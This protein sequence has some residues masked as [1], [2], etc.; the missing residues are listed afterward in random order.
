RKALEQAV[1][2]QP[3][4]APALNN[5]GYVL[6]HL[7]RFAEAAECYGQAIAVNPNYAEAYCNLASVRALAGDYD[8]ALALARRAIELKP[9]YL[10]PP[11]AAAVVEA[12]RGRFDE[13]LAWVE[14]L[15]PHVRRD[16][17]VLVTQA[18]IFANAGRGED[19]I[20]L[21]TEV[22]ALQPE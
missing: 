18:Q 11:L 3:R 14:R 10:N 17:M 13:A 21:C 2:L 19:A 7:R 4:F 22:I 15:P 20:P 6:Q 8:N 9:D 16:P 5:L 1:R 12:D